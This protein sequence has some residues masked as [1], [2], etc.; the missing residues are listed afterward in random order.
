MVYLFSFSVCLRVVG[1]R[2]GYAILKETGE[3]SGEGRCELWPSIRNY[4]GMEAKSRENMSKK[5]LGNSCHID[6][7]L[8]R[9][10]KLPPS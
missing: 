3:F 5:E 1:S 10:S 9:G 6:V 8:C 7:F 2:E 4:F